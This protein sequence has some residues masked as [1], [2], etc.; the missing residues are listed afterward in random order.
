MSE[1]LTRGLVIDLVSLSNNKSVKKRQDDKLH[2]V[3]RVEGL[4]SLVLVSWQCE[5][6]SI[7]FLNFIVPCHWI[8]G[9]LSLACER[10]HSQTP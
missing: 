4:T 10:G 6:V 9:S 3:S 1:N 2:Q 7:T 5:A 8:Q